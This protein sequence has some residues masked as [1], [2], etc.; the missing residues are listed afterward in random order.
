VARSAAKCGSRAPGA[1]VMGRPLAGWRDRRVARKAASRRACPASYA[2]IVPS[3]IR[4]VRYAADFQFCESAAATKQGE[5][6]ALQPCW[7]A[8]ARAMSPTHDAIMVD[9]RGHGQSAAP[10]DGYD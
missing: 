8:C 4:I 6:A 7:T 10:P 5:Y 2:A 3:S 1:V 9:A